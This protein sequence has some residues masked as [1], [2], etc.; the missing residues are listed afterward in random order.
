MVNNDDDT[1]RLFNPNW[2]S[3][4]ESNYCT[5]IEQQVWG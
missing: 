4:S 1:L 2:T 3:R 5:D